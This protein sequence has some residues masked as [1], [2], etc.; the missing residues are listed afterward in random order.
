MAGKPVKRPNKRRIARFTLQDILNYYPISDMQAFALAG[1]TRST[2]RRWKAGTANPPPAIV[3]L[4]RLYAAGKVIPESF[5][6]CYFQGD[7][8]IDDY[9]QKHTLG[10][11]RLFSL[12]RSQ[13]GQ[14]QSVL[15]Y[16]DLVPKAKAT[17]AKKGVDALEYAPPLK[18]Y[19]IK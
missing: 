4:I 11:L 7:T 9:G 3:E 10:D 13:A 18:M 2:W 19:S 6:D 17:D 5:T 16:N 12:Y 15:R 14:L 8:L 1:V